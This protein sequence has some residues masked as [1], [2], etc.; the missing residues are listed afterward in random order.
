KPNEAGEQ[1]VPESLASIARPTARPRDQVVER[2]HEWARAPTGEMEI[3][4]VIDVWADPLDVALEGHGIFIGGELA[5]T[6]AAAAGHPVLT[7]RQRRSVE[8]HVEQERQVGVESSPDQS[9][10]Q[11]ARVGPHAPDGA[12]T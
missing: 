12:R 4:G 8:S 3:D 2:D 11:P 6:A 5:V 7:H 1:H 9:L 10:Q